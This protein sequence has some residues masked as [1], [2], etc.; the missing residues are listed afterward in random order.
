[1]GYGGTYE[2]ADLLT[3]REETSQQLVLDG[4]GEWA[5]VALKVFCR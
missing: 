5:S 4:V 3:E 1:M 2:G